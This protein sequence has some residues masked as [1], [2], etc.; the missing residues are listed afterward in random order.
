[1]KTCLV[2]ASRFLMFNCIIIILC[3]YCLPDFGEYSCLYRPRKVI[4][5]SFEQK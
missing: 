2:H 3:V 4:A 5:K 1:V